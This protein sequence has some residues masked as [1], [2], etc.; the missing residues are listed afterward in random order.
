MDR[1]ETLSHEEEIRKAKRREILARLDFFDGGADGKDH[2]REERLG[3]ER[4][5]ELAKS[6]HHPGF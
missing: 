2:E 6:W 3:L 1:G 5:S 4:E